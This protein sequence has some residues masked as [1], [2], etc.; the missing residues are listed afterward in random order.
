MD[1]IIL[2]DGLYYLVPITAE[3]LISETWKD[4]FDLC[5]IVKKKISLYDY[6]VNMHILKDGTYFF[7]CMCR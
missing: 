7:G 4:C 6:Q 1:L 2:K 5:N 3:L